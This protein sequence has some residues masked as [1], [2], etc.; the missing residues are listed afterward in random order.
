MKRKQIARTASFGLRIVI[1]L[2]A[3]GL[4]L[5]ALA[6]TLVDEP[7]VTSHQ[8]NDSLQILS[9]REA[10]QKRGF[11]ESTVRFMGT[12]MGMTWRP[13]PRAAFLLLV[14]LR[15]RPAMRIVTQ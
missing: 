3:V 15:L 7:V 2:V 14:G 4:V 6:G 10:S 8:D 12:T 5:A 1:G 13:I 9:R 11:A